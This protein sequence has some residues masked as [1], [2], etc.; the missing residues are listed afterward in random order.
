MVMLK[1]YQVETLDL[2]RDSNAQFTTTTALNRYINLS[3]REIAKRSAC[4]QALVT[5]QSPF[6]TSAQP[7]YA[8]PGA[9]VPGML[10]ASNPDNENEP[11]ADATTSNAFMTIPGVEL[12][13][14]DYANPFLR[15]QYKGY[16]RVIYVSSVAVS[17]GGQMPVLNWMP[18][19]DLQ[20]YA[21]AV[22]LG[23]SSYPQAWSQKGVGE[24]GQIFLFPIPT[25][26]DS[27]TMEWECICTPKPL[28]S[29]SDFEVIP[30]IYQECVK[31]YAAYLAFLGQQ[32]TGQASIMRGLFDEQLMISG[33]SS[34][35]GHVE[36]YYRTWP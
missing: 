7:G 13:T 3:R 12:Y 19:D 26:L 28:Y 6:G 24:N 15:K 14:Y 10:P 31:Y 20:A 17:W 36:S 35:W 11:G 22:N 1:D 29:N 8:I 33:V 27:A 32:R 18:W 9:M 5:G 2:L 34:D 16:D 25:N 4:L 23:V 30:E 21:R